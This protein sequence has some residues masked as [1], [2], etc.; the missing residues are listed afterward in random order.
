MEGGVIVRWTVQRWSLLLVLSLTIVA[1]A[2]AA[3]SDESFSLFPYRLVTS[4]LFGQISDSA[5]PGSHVPVDET[6]PL[7]YDV[8][9]KEY[10]KLGL[11]P[12]KDYHPEPHGD[13]T[14][15]N[16]S[17]N[18]L[19]ALPPGV[20]W[21]VS[22]VEGEER[23]EAKGSEGGIGG[24]GEIADNMAFTVDGKFYL[25]VLE[26]KVLAKYSVVEFWVS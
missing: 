8:G 12:S 16:H 14:D 4:T 6:L 10:I 5:L 25:S 21:R 15:H 23:E 2:S 17:T 13:V 9:E 3:E 26:P 24:E 1:S 11:I 20:S 22:E 18:V 7:S 19:L